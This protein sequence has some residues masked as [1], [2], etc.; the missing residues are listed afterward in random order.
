LN[1]YYVSID[2]KNSSV[3]FP[4]FLDEKEAKRVLTANLETAKFL[5]IDGYLLNYN[6][7]LD[8]SFTTKFGNQSFKSVLDK[9]GWNQFYYSK[10]NEYSP[11][12][13][14]VYPGHEEIEHLSLHNLYG[15]QHMKIVRSFF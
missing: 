4:S 5:D 11:T 3:L 12:L 8:L 13:D 10:L 7:P 6:T 15:Y 14:L 2:L 1:L 9:Y